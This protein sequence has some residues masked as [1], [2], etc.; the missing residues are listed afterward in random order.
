VALKREKL[1]T[2]GFKGIIVKEQKPPPGVLEQRK[3]EEKGGIPSALIGKEKLTV[4]K[5]LLKTLGIRSQV[6]REDSKKNRLHIQ[7]KRGGKAQYYEWEQ[8]FCH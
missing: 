4:R 1:G 2:K 6:L 3:N 5:S 7:A 8:W